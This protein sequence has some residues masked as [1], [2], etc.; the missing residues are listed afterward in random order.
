M[1]TAVTVA[2]SF[3]LLTLAWGQ[4]IEVHSSEQVKR[5]SEVAATT[6]AQR[7]RF[8]GAWSPTVLEA[9]PSLQ[10]L[11][12]NVGIRVADSNGAVLF[13]GLPSDENGNPQPLDG[14]RS[15]ARQPIVVDGLQVGTVWLVALEMP[16]LSESNQQFRFDSYQ[17]ITIAGVIAI[18]L[19]FLFSMLFSRSLTSPLQY[20]V[21]VANEVRHGN[22][23]VRTDMT[24][25]DEFAQLGRAMDE[26]VA[27]IERNVVIER[28]LTIGMAHELRTPLMAMQATIEAMIDGALPLDRARLAILDSEVVRLGRLV[29]AQLRLARL[30]RGS[31]TMQVE[32]LNLT[33]LVSDLVV[34]NEVLINNAELTLSFTA[35]S[36]VMVN[37]DADLLLQATTNLISN[38]VQYTPAG[39]QITIEVRAVRQVAQIIVS[40][41]GVGISPED[42]AQIFLRFW[43]ANSGRSSEDDSLGIGLA[44]TKGIANLHRGWV[45]VEST[46][47]KGSIFTINIPLLKKA[48]IRKSL[49]GKK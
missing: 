5:L 43:R 17:A 16:Y 14:D 35:G 20:I 1:V 32:E 9:L 49:R 29:E 22:L 27:S 21:S 47:G 40:D 41:T 13:D 36:N 7:Y 44:M 19:T 33:E 24:G 2:I 46:L 37:G 31:D 8:V 23:S 39:G 26:M 18:I 12:G 48:A 38:A 28:Q 10:K 6:L 34:A 15:L 11:V 30:E 45:D 25:R 42:I 3:V 4:R